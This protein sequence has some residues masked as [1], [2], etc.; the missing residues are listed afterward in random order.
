MIISTTAH[1]RGAATLLIGAK[2][3]DEAGGIRSKVAFDGSRK[4]LARAFGIRHQ[5]LFTVITPTAYA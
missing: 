5:R 1:N 2:S 4:H 3:A